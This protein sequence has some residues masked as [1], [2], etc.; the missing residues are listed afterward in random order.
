[1]KCFP[2]H[3][4]TEQTVLEPE[5]ALPTKPKSSQ[6]A[7][8]YLT[9]TV[10]FGMHPYRSKDEDSSVFFVD[11]NRSIRKMIIDSVGNIQ[12]FP[13]IVKESF[14]LQHVAPNYVGQQVCFRSSFERRDNGWIFIW[15]LQPDG[16]YWADEG[17]FGAE[18]DL[19]VK[20]YTYLDLNGD[21]T[22]PFR[23]YK[24]GNVGYSMDRFLGNHVRSQKIAMEEIADDKAPVFWYPD[25]IFPQLL[26]GKT[27][28]ISE[29]QYCL[30]DKEDALAY[31]NEPVLSK[32]MKELAQ[33]MLDSDKT[34]W[35]MMGNASNRVQ[36]SMTL[37]WL[38][39]Q[40]PVFMQM[41]DKFYKGELHKPTVERLRETE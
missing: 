5:T 11:E 9:E 17:G 33:A 38:I 28:H 32:D 19:E 23:I 37:F 30:R 18:N 4:E 15:Q 3:F 12:N 7:S 25:S 16:W 29:Q 14:W 8:G 41:L 1:M 31:W 26:G 6:E 22:G 13:G 27:N 2:K 40:E 21:F 20:L 35:Q 34:L 39:T 24:L 36:A 10:T